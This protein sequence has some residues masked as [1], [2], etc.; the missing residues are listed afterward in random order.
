MSELK[1][2]LTDRGFSHQDCIEKPDLLSKAM[3]VKSAEMTL[4]N[5]V[6]AS[7]KHILYSFYQFF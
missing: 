4:H 5:S 1:A 3:R 7:F 2:F 6:S